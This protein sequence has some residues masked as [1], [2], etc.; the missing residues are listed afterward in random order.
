[1]PD[2]KRD[3]MKT[4][5][6]MRRMVIGL[7]LA[8]ALAATHSVARA[9]LVYQPP[10]PPTSSDLDNAWRQAGSQLFKSV[11]LVNDALSDVELKRRDSAAQKLDQA[12]GMLKESI[13]SY[14]RLAETLNRPRV[15]SPAKLT[16]DGRRRLEGLQSVYGIKPPANEAEA[17]RLARDECQR[18]LEI[19]QKSRDALLAAN[20]QAV[21]D[22]L[23]SI[24][25]LQRVG[26]ETAELMTTVQP[27]ER[28]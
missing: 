10:P 21:R 18:A 2:G 28:K 14:G 8:A 13:S 16:D 27:A 20:L 25:R 5:A 24:A 17:A 26:I 22:V 1:M 15:V 3:N 7:G 19:Y 6:K 12:A 11:A 23:G 4:P 9:E